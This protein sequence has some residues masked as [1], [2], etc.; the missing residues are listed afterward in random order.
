MGASAPAHRLADAE[1]LRRQVGHGGRRGRAQR[2]RA[3]QGPGLVFARFELPPPDAPLEGFRASRWWTLVIALCASV[4]S[5]ASVFIVWRVGRVVVLKKKP[6]PVFKDLPTML[7]LGQ[8][9]IDG[10]KPT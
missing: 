5:L 6:P 4:L 10:L 3:P 1:I 2:Q 9:P 8:T 7:L